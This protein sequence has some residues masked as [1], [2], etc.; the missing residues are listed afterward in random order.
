MTR[1]RWSLLALILAVLTVWALDACFPP[2]LPTLAEDLSTVVVDRNDRPLRAFASRKRVWRFAVTADQV[3]PDYLQALFAFEDRHFFR[4][5]GV[6]PAAVVRAGWQALASGRVVSGAS[7]L[8]MQ[9]ARILS[10]QPRTIGAKFKQMLRALQMERRLSKRE[11]L[12]LYLNYAPF[13]GTV[14]GVEAASFAYLGKSARSLSLAEAALLVAL[15]QAPSRLRPD[16]HPEAA[17]KARDKVLKRMVDLEVITADAAAAAMREPVEA[18]R[19]AVPMWAPHLA[20]RL[21]SQHPREAVIHSTIDIEL[22]MGLEARV[23][24]YFGRLDRRV[25]A[26]VLVMDHRDGAVLAYLGGVEFGDPKRAGHIDLVQ[27]QRSPGSTLKPFIYGLALDEGLIHSESLLLDVPLNFQGYNPQNFDRRFT[28]P[29]AASLALK[30]SLNLPAVQLLD[31]IT[32]NLFAARLQHAGLPLALPAGGTPNLS[33]ALGGGAANLEALVRAHSALAH[34]G[35]SLKPRLLRDDPVEQRQVLSAG[36]A[37]IVRDMLR[38]RG[39]PW[40]SWKTGTSYGYRDAW[41]VGSTPD[42]SAGVWVGRPDGTPL[43]GSMGADTALPLL[44]QILLAMPRHTPR[45]LPPSSVSRVDICWPTGRAATDTPPELCAR[46]G[47]ALVLDGLVPPTLAA[48]GENPG[49]LP[50]VEIRV[51]PQSGRRLTLGCAPGSGTLMQRARWPAELGPW[52]DPALAR[53]QTMPARR[54]DCLADGLDELEAMRI[55]GLPDNAHL[56]SLPGSRRGP[57]AVLQAR[58]SEGQVRWLI[59]GELAAALPASA[60]FDHTF[61][62]TGPIDVLAIGDHGRYARLRLTIE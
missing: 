39:K 8:T 31:R 5:P 18:R 46:R 61:E 48:P 12:D 42:Y 23:A 20:Q 24:E 9:V 32:P 49:W 52:L 16:R 21:R 15:P 56:R 55:D 50:L 13:G 41:A 35:S 30:R 29:V 45:E 1:L 54:A 28:G 3:A 14:Q 57:R 58:G 6:N 26:A 59:N 19:L 40:L 25:S 43:P 62:Q 53:T 27:A 44:R 7:T 47:N 22:Q 17:R 33:L 37:Y 10:P 51:D 11:I 36:A 60:R 38:D 34:G 4:H 2:P